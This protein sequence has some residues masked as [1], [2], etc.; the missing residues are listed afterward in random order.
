MRNNI[1]DC[2]CAVSIQF[3][4]LDESQGAKTAT[5]K[6]TPKRREEETDTFPTI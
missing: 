5:A 1:T 3:A 2:Y 4:L 6:A